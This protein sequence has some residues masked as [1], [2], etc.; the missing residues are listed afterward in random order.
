MSIVG[1]P[2]RS[3]T[4]KDPEEAQAKIDAAVAER[5]R[6]KKTYP[7]GVPGYI[8]DK[9]VENQFTVKGAPEGTKHYTRT[10]PTDDNND[11][12][13]IEVWSIDKEGNT[14]HIGNY[15]REDDGTFGDFN[16][17]D[18]WYRW[19]TGTQISK[20]EYEP[21]TKPS[22]KQ[23]VLA[24]SEESV[25]RHIKDNCKGDNCT[26]E[27]DAEAERLG[28][29]D[30]QNAA[31]EA[32]VI[33]QNAEE[34]ISAEELEAAAE[35]DLKNAQQRKAYE[36]L[37]YPL[38]LESDKQD[39]IM[40]SLVEYLPRGLNSKGK[41]G[42]SSRS[43]PATTAAKGMVEGQTAG[44]RKILGSAI[45][46]IPAGIQDQNNIDWSDD[47]M[48]PIK[49]GIG[50]I[51]DAAL[52]PNGDVGEAVSTEVNRT[53]TNGRAIHQAMV[54]ELSGIDAT[55]RNLGAVINKNTELLFGGP[56]LRSFNFTFRLSPRSKDEAKVVKK[57][58]RFFKQG[59]SAKK[60][61]NFMF[62][63]SP[64]TFFIHY[65]AAGGKV[66]PWLNSFKECALSGV[67]VQYTPDGQYSTFPDG[68]M[69]SYSLQLNFKELEP[70]FDSDYKDLDSDN[71]SS[72]GY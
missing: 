46:P 47:S 59:A 64:H 9:E 20:E 33:E 42:L 25:R 1:G 50:N 24:Q 19:P 48:D 13:T 4:L 69:T 12:G 39:F 60:G 65:Y 18:E 2:I 70:V 6:L 35:A 10:D 51:T 17:N 16:P 67:S 61:E 26:D 53:A 44:E 28:A 52:D 71:D 37:K 63:K 66:H 49:Q 8:G 68:A 15:Y 55:K 7:D 56:K 14:R 38:S 11:A 57:I 34:G 32:A 23:T 29:S 43:V 21:F 58:I 30:E 27:A 54:S 45:L 3:T 72:I 31:L 62:I 5:E 22:G 40:F 41:G 36:N